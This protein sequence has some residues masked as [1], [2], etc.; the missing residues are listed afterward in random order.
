MPGEIR[1]VASGTFMEEPPNVRFQIRGWPGDFPVRGPEKFP[2]G[3]I[4]ARVDY[5]DSLVLLVEQF[6][7]TLQ[8]KV[9]TRVRAGEPISI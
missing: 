3:R 9:A 1:L 8:G 5:A 2:L 6:E 7:A 4:R